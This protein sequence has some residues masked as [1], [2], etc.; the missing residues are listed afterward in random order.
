M[1][2]KSQYLQDRE[3]FAKKQASNYTRESLEN[4]FGV[5]IVPNNNGQYDILQDN[6]V[7]FEAQEYW[8]LCQIFQEIIK[9]IPF[10]DLF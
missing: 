8:Q 2:D 5:S 7:L 3:N 1:I 10:K 6:K 9:Q 4:F